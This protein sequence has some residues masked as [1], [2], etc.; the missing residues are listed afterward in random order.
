MASTNWS[1]SEAT[2][3]EVTK[4]VAGINEFNEQQVPASHP[5][6]TPIEL[7][8]SDDHGELIGGLLGGVGCWGGL[9]IKILWVAERYRAEGL[10]SKLLEKA[11]AVATAQGA[12]HAM[13]DT[14]DFQARDFYLKKGYT[15]AGEITG[16]PAGHTR[17]YCYKKLTEALDQVS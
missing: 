1:I 12:T 3:A 15:I 6:W 9:E 16:F 14:F 4:I 2:K 7:A 8:I 17:Y 13:L 10:G 5:T 11:E